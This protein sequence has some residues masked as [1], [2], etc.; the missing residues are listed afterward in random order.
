LLRSQHQ[1]QL[2]QL[3]KQVVATIQPRFVLNDTQMAK[4]SN[5]HLLIIDLDAGI[6]ALPP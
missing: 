6:S 5:A 2:F 4:R 3:D 1:L